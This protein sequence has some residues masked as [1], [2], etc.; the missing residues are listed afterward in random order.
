MGYNRSFR[1]HTRRR[2]RGGLTASDATH[3]IN[4][5]TSQASQS[6]SNTTSKAATAVKTEG[7]EVVS[8]AKN[9]AEKGQAAVEGWF[10]KLSGLFGSA[11]A[12]VKNIFA[13][14]GFK[15]GRVTLRRIKVGGKCPN[16]PCGK[17][18]KSLKGGKKKRRTYKK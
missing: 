11:P 12:G 17:T 5:K 3:T 9:T 18:Q 2:R 4:D 13:K 6:V 15:G 7:K 16:C 8:A 14:F 1:K 10:S